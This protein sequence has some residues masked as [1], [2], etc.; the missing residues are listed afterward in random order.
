MGSILTN[1]A[2]KIVM[3]DSEGPEVQGL[4]EMINSVFNLDG[5]SGTSLTTV[6][7]RTLIGS[8]VY[9]EDPLVNEEIMVPLMGVINQRYV[10]YILAAL[11]IF[12][13]ENCKTVSDTL[14]RVGTEGFEISPVFDPAKAVSDYF[15]AGLEAYNT[16]K[17]FKNDIEENLKH[18]AAGRLLE[19]GINVPGKN[20]KGENVTTLS[21]IP[22]YVQLYPVG[23]PS[24]VAVSL[25]TLN[26][27]E[28]F[29]RRALKTY[30]REIHFFKDFI[31]SMDLAEQQR[32][33]LRADRNGILNR[34]YK[35]R[36]SKQ[37][38]R[39]WDIITGSK[40]NN[41]ANSVIVITA[42]TFKKINDTAH[43]D[44]NTPADRQR[45]FNDAYA[46]SLV[47]VD[48]TF[49][50]VEFYMN[51]IPNGSEVPFRAIKQSGSSKQGVDI[52]E[53]IEA[54]A[55]GTSPKY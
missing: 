6:L 9:I 30:T 48:T 37:L 52:A 14:K 50:M 15:E 4:R 41:L 38:H 16:N 53:L 11:N 18:L 26:Y 3:D 39:V 36:F 45:F 32:A 43:I 8:N 47:V 7:K 49:N 31:L 27:P 51:G 34:F 42:D 35:D 25:I 23:M 33:A 54:F 5:K 40:H 19:V 21:S 2:S 55:K 1:L 44:L 13:I 12:D 29:L 20:D 17:K 22:L 28:R 24:D 10:G 46:M